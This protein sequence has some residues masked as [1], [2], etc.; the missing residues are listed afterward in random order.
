MGLG[1]SEL[2]CSHQRA[3]PIC[4]RL[5]GDRGVIEPRLCLLGAPKRR[6]GPRR[7]Q[8]H[9][10]KKKVGFARRRSSDRPACSGNLSAVDTCSSIYAPGRQP[11]RLRP[12]SALAERCLYTTERTGKTREMNDSESRQPQP[13]H[14]RHANR[15]EGLHAAPATSLVL[16]LAPAVPRVSV[17]EPAVDLVQE[18]VAPTING[19]RGGG[20]GR[21]GGGA[22]FFRATLGCAR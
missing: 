16:G 9:R 4:R 22:V 15:P 12:D 5:L 13:A 6:H 21:G 19:R 11:A 10:V 3:G 14:E 8:G 2:E 1:K 18:S 17:A 7:R 20:G